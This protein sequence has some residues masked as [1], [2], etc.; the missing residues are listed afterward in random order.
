MG[1]S[2]GPFSIRN[3]LILNTWLPKLLACWP[4]AGGQGR[5]VGKLSL[6]GVSGRVPEVSCITADHMLCARTQLPGYAYLQ[7][8]PA[9]VAYLHAQEQGEWAW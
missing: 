7:R 3:P 8:C 5:S 4:Q 9:D 6:V 1:S 2:P